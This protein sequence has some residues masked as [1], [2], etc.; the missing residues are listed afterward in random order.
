MV[1]YAL[2]VNFIIVVSCAAC[3]VKVQQ[4]RTPHTS[5][6]H[7]EVCVCLIILTYKASVS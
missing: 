3:F 1:D 7:V 2:H 5:D 6:K 4:S